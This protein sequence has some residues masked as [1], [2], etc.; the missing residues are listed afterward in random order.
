MDEK[1]GIVC[2]VLL[3]PIRVELF[4]LE[5]FLLNLSLSFYL[6]PVEG[7]WVLLHS[8]FGIFDGRLLYLFIL[9]LLPDLFLPLE[10]LVIAN[11]HEEGVVLEARAEFPL[12]LADQ[13]SSP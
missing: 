1:R 3:F 13:I 12:F 11:N 2:K 6:C 5:F 9:V 8:D 7:F 10:S 4:L